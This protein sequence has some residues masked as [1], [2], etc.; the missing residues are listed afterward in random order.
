MTDRAAEGRVPTTSPACTGAG[1][2]TFPRHQYHQIALSSACCG[3]AGRDGPAVPV[4]IRRA[5]PSCL[6]AQA[7]RPA[8]NSKRR[9]T[10]M[11]TQALFYGRST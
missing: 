10:L 2:A 1:W 9:G 8:S 7:S 5:G 4:S 11:L 3:S 6:L